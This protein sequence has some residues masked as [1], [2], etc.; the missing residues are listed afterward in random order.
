MVKFLGLLLLP[1]FS[2]SQTQLWI[3]SQD[4]KGFWLSLNGAL[5]N[6]Q[7]VPALWLDGIPAN[8][9][10]TLL[11][12]STRIAKSV[13]LPPGLHHYVIAR[14]HHGH[15]RLRYRGQVKDK[16][17]NLSP[18][19]V[20]TGTPAPE[21]WQQLAH[22]PDPRR[23]ETLREGLFAPGSLAEDSVPKTPQPPDSLRVTSAPSDT[24]TPVLAADNIP[25]DTAAHSTVTPPPAEPKVLFPEVMARA[26]AEEFEFE[27]LRLLLNFSSE[28]EITAAQVKEV[29]ALLKYDQTRLQFLRESLEQISDP[30][31]LSGLKDQLDYQHSRE[32][33]AEILKP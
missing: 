14:D 9:R 20:K 28:N 22:S 8:A 30:E 10:L 11:Y 24:A 12:D 17:R 33:L 29:F 27:K 5:Q 18:S 23:L 6:D 4:E 21:T 31:K 1:L 26:G 2:L 16:P 25:A 32:Q 13:D 3:E 15:P 19:R 7:A